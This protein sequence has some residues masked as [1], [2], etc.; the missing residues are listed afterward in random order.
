M[1]QQRFIT[2]ARVSTQ[3]Q[4]V[5]GLGLE[6]QQHSLALYLGTRR[7]RVVA[8][9]VEVESGRRVD[10]PELL[11]ALAACRVHG[12]T[13]VVAKID[14]LARNAAFLLA[15]RDSGVDFV[16]TDIPQA[17][18]LTIGILAVVAQAEAEAIS[19]RAREAALA[20]I[21]RGDTVGNRAH[22]GA[23]GLRK[24][25]RAQIA[26]RRA[27]AEARAWRLTPIVR[28]LRARG[29]CSCQAIADALNTQG[30]PAS[31]GGPWASC[32]VHLLL[33]RIDRTALYEALT[34]ISKRLRTNRVR[35][36]A[37]E[38]DL[39]AYLERLLTGRPNRPSVSASATST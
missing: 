5:S 25:I 19:V 28:D 22:F 27:A 26:T 36:P 16:C 6:A 18:R 37:G 35:M 7:C 1:P 9:F 15:M 4:G 24:G 2:Y 38:L 30:I 31:R 3:R 23:E 13:L 12:A 39:R 11:K 10:R 8:E 34:L 21:R 29:T 33:R 17:N 32:S 20:R 14:R